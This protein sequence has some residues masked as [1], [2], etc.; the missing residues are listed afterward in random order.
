M[1][2][3]HQGF[4]CGRNQSIE[5]TSEANLDT[6]SSDIKMIS[7]VEN[8]VLWRSF[9]P[10]FLERFPF[11]LFKNA[12]HTTFLENIIPRYKF[13]GTILYQRLCSGLSNI[14]RNAIIV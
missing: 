2:I 6:Q 5:R 4:G 11:D 12:S 7:A 9:R 8:R 14:T 13:I 1:T 10:P 3:F